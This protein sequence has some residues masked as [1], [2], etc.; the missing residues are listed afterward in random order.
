MTFF[1]D[2][3]TRQDLNLMDR[4][5]NRSVYAIF[6]QVKTSGASR[7]LEKMF[8][9]PLTAHEAI[10]SRSSIFKFFETLDIE[11][12]IEDDEFSIVESYLQSGGI[13][14][15]ARLSGLRA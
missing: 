15:M 3:Q 5:S 14:S 10:N 4:Y 11:F 2:I 1:T 13:G 6:N 8:N 7:L 9:S 12:P